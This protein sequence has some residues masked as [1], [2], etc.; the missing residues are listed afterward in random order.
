MASI[1]KR[2][3]NSYQITVSYGVDAQN[4]RI[5]HRKTVTI[6]GDPESRSHQQ[7]LAKQVALFTAEVEKGSVTTS[8]NLKLKEFIETVWLPLHVNR[9]DKALA[10]KT[11]WRYK[12]LL[13]RINYSLGNIKLKDLKPAQIMA[14]ISDLSQPGVR[15]SLSRDKEKKEENQQ[16][17]LSPQTIL[18]HFRLLHS[19]LEKA[20]K[21]QYLT[22]NPASAVESPSVEKKPRRKAFSEDQVKTLQAELMKRS[23]R[24]QALILITLATGARLGEVLSLTWPRVNLKSGEI[25]IQ[26]AYQYVPGLGTF[27]KAP[28]N[29]SSNRTVTL[30]PPIVEILKSWRKAQQ[31]EI[32]TLADGWKDKDNA[33]FTSFMGTRIAPDTISTWFPKWVV[34]IGLPRVTFHGLRHTAASLLIAYGATPAEVANLL[35][36]S[37]IGTTMN[38]Y[39]H[40]FDDASKNMAAKMTD[41]LFTDKKEAPKTPKKTRK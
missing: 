41:I 2:G 11:A 5:R 18:H 40:N 33:I 4:K 29:E 15:K 25:T 8:P 21:W 30:P 17:P 1:Q 24:D 31:E 36:H 27:E 10:P 13:A 9:K 22:I 28:K 26:K 35:G 23:L 19:I 16:K 14:F 20:K 34:S 6:P 32:S 12:Q 39:V 3:Q 7:A 38:I 37:T